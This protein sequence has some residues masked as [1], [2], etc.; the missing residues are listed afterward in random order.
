MIF[1]IWTICKNN[2]YSHF[3]RL[4]YSTVW[5]VGD[6][7]L[8]I[9]I[10][11]FFF[12]LLT[13]QRQPDGYKYLVICKHLKIIK[14][15]ILQ[16]RNHTLIFNSLICKS[17]TREARKASKFTEFLMLPCSCLDYHVTILT[18]ERDI[19]ITQQL[20][21]LSSQVSKLL[22]DGHFC[23]PSLSLSPKHSLY[24]NHTYVSTPSDPLCSPLS[25][26]I[27]THNFFGFRH[28]CNP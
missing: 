14:S 7:Q 12:C 24:T 27:I 18:Q 3:R 19:P 25:F 23:M 28:L 10:T 2:A 21:L 6:V 5:M 15:V 13:I 20:Y 4:S 8:F 16:I 11:L 22:I 17:R 26:I 9:L 1:E